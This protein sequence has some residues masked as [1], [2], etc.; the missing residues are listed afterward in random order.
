MAN[1]FKK[2]RFIGILA[3]VLLVAATAIILIIGTNESW[4]GTSQTEAA[5][6][7]LLVYKNGELTSRP[8]R[9]FAD[10]IADADKPVFVD[11]WAEWCAP[12][13]LASPF[14]ESLA[15]EYAGEAYIVKVNIDEQLGVANSNLVQSIP[16]FIV[17]DGG[18]RRA[19]KTGYSDQMQPELR[20]MIDLRLQS[21]D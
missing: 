20:S 3:A 9:K 2:P 16:T 10:F 12:C 18:K 17:F 15:E 7:R 13:K 14:V 1:T 4:F 11:F 5:D 6:A 21:E 8:I 19:S